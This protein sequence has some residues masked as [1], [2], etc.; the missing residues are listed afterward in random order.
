MKLKWKKLGPVPIGYALTE[1]DFTMVNCTAGDQRW[2]HI[3]MNISPKKEVIDRVEASKRSSSWSGLS[4]YW[5]SLDSMSQMAFRRLLPKTVEYL[6]KKMGSIVLN[7]YNIVGDGTPQ[8][9]IPILTGKT[10]LELPLTRKRYANAKFVDV[11]PFIW[12]NFS[13]AGY[14]TMYGEDAANIG[15]FTYRLKGFRNRPTDHY[16]RTFFLL[17]EKFFPSYH[18]FGSETQFQAW[19]RYGQQFME[20]Y[21]KEVPKFAVLHHRFVTPTLSAKFKIDCFSD[22]S[23]DDITLVKL[24]DNDLKS[25]FEKLFEGG[26]LDNAVVFVGADHG[27]RFS[28]LRET[29][30]GQMEERL[31]FMSVFLPESFKSTPKGQKAYRN[32]QANA[33][34]LT[35]P[36]D[37]HATFEDILS[38]PDDLDVVQSP[39][40]RSLS[41]LRPI[42]ESRSCEQAG[43]EPHWCTCL[44]WQ[45]GNENV[46]TELAKAVVQTINSYTEKERKLCAPLSLQKLVDAK[47]LVPDDKV[48]KYGNFLFYRVTL[49]TFL[50]FRWKCRRRWIRAK[51]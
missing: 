30:Q 39:E 4:V 45:A 25:H 36:F 9:F 12:K 44:S 22:L 3:F 49:L 41:L 40:K 37:I 42:I 46:S 29:Q 5:F 16:T 18:C 13:D 31:P 1:G 15:T 38:L 24:A 26:F 34:V 33:E 7:G 19:I 47:K 20:K 27:H 48:L 11:Y 35:T 2:K 17:S 32:L 21:P 6:E 10:E 14:A 23:H 8:A 28:A 43:I 50:F 51:V